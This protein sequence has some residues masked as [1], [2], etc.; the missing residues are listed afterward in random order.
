MI[1]DYFAHIR[2]RGENQR[3]PAEVA[4]TLSGAILILQ[5]CWWALISK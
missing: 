3:L 4:R 1:N 5:L 2:R